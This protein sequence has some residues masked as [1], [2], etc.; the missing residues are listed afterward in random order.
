M[1]SP[2]GPVMSVSGLVVADLD[3][4]V[5]GVAHVDRPPVAAG[6]RRGPGSPTS[7]NDTRSAAIDS[8]VARSA[9]RHTWSTFGSVTGPFA[10]IRSRIESGET[11]T[12]GNGR[13]PARHSVDPFGGQAEHV[14]VPPQRC[15]DVGAPQHDVIE[16]DERAPPH[17]A[18][19]SG[20]AAVRCRP[21]RCRR[22]RGGGCR[23]GTRCRGRRGAGLLDHLLHLR[24]DG[25][26]LDP[27][28]RGADEVVV[29]AHEVLGQLVAPALVA[30]DDAVGDADLLEHDEV[31]VDRALGQRRPAG[32]QLGDG[33]RAG[34]LGE[35]VDD[36]P[37]AARVALVGARSRSATALCSC[38]REPSVTG[39]Q[40]PPG[41]GIAENRAAWRVDRGV[42]DPLHAVAVGGRG[43]VERDEAVA[44]RARARR[45]RR[46]AS[47]PSG[48]P[49]RRRAGRR[50]TRRG[51]TG[52]SSTLRLSA[53]LAKRSSQPGWATPSLGVER[54]RLAHVGEVR[55]R[56]LR[57]RTRR[58]AS[59]A[60]CRGAA[61]TGD[62][63][64]R[65]VGTVAAG[66]LGT[67]G[68]RPAP[69]GGA[70]RRPR[71]SVAADRR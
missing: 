30:G 32:E 42:R 15:F 62:A 43:D 7:R 24:R 39:E 23:H 35:Q 26:V 52:P 3:D 61:T 10:G 19:G 44:A 20:W 13:D 63:G 56:P 12:D 70:T 2:P 25:E 5:V 9:T 33:G 71:R 34:S 57:R 54:Q 21:R 41:L 67:I 59:R 50:R 31:A 60:R 8:T 11:R 55:R 16:P 51:S 53:A 22:C 14:D 68:P 38:C 64:G 18:D 58:R 66:G 27:A 40:L 65:T 49:R 45:G 4:V 48:R 46:R 29:V 1:C 37:A 36:G 17:A 28:A 69:S 6:T 47:R